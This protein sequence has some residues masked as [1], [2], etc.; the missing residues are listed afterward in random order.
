MGIARWDVS[1]VRLMSGMF[2]G[3]TSFNGD[4]SKWQVSSVINMKNMFRNAR[5]FDQK[6]CGARWVHSKAI[7][8]NMF[9]GSTGSISSDVCTSTQPASEETCTSTKHVHYIYRHENT[10]APKVFPIRA[11]ASTAELKRA[12]AASL[13]LSPKGDYEIEID[14]H[15]DCPQGK[16]GDWDV[17]SVTDMSDLFNGAV[18]FN[19]DIS[20]WDVSR[21]K[22]MSG[23]FQG[24]IA[25][26]GDLS[27]WDVSSVKDT[28]CMFKGASLF[29][30][31]LS[32][33]D[34]SSVTNMNEMFLDATTFEE[35]RERHMETS[36]P[37]EATPEATPEAPPVT[38]DATKVVS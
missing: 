13:Q 19:G 10:A 11:I 12:V 9:Q 28:S 23:M 2:Q 34:V 17:S 38:R 4:I 29:D 15:A 36:P 18:G 37:P 3:A 1:N 6:L 32:K 20:K 30:G 31:D 21:V 8:T 33:W 22:D 14:Y 26:N 16:I 25:F 35:S 27:Q 7:N 24:A 5:S